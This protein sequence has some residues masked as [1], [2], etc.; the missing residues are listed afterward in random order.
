[1]AQQK[2]R[3]LAILLGVV[4]GVLGIHRFYLGYTKIGIIQLLT[5][6]GLGIWYIIDVVRL[7]FGGLPPKHGYY[8]ATT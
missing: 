2:S 1:M 8:S 6:G 7:L 5:A 3:L 4:T